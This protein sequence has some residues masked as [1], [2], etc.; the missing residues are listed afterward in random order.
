M[1]KSSPSGQSWQNCELWHRTRIYDIVDKL[2]AA[3][4]AVIVF[5]ARA[6]VGTA[7]V[8]FTVT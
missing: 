8:A 1:F 6:A 3:S 2:V 5:A 7:I 4:H